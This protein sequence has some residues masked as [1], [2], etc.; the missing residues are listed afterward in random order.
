MYCG[1]EMNQSS[2]M[3]DKQCNYYRRMRSIDP[4]EKYNWANTATHTKNAIFIVLR[5]IDNIHINSLI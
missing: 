2:M 4:G 5:K 3:S 1:R